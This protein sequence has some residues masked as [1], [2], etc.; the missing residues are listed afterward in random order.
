MKQELTRNKINSPYNKERYSELQKEVTNTPKFNTLEIHKTDSV[1]LK[2]ST[3]KM[4]Q[5]SDSEN[6]FKS[7]YLSDNEWGEKTNLNERM[8]RYTEYKT[9]QNSPLK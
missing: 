8:T 2:R 7:D 9:M 3:Q 1:E 5:K 4:Y 6:S